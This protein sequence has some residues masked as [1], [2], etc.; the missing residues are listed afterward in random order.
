[1]SNSRTC[2]TKIYVLAGTALVFVGSILGSYRS[3]QTYAL[4]KGVSSEFG[5]AE[6][7]TVKSQQDLFSEVDIREVE[8]YWNRRP[9]NSGWKFPGVQFGTKA[10]FEKVTERR[11]LV[12]PHIPDFAGFSSSRNK[13]VL[14][15]GSGICTDTLMFA[16]AGANVT[17]VDLS[18]SSVQLCNRRFSFYPKYNVRVIHGNA[19][20]IDRILPTE[21]F[22]IIYSFG[23]I[24]HSPHPDVILGKLRNMLAHKGELRIMMYNKF[25]Y[26]LF[27]VQRDAGIWDFTHLDSIL[28]KYSEAQTGSPVTYTYTEQSLSDL[29]VEAGYQVTSIHKNHIFRYDIPHYTKGILKV[30]QEFVGMDEELFTSMKAELGW[31]LLATAELDS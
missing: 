10:W 9:C 26:K 22:D 28:A 4:N 11:Y 21:K 20:N 25:S 8:D 7:G 12:E 24:H 31:H 29:L 13:K 6:H 17:T 3:H 14:E 2:H 27:Q 16:K 23:V 18:S 1:M 15:I 19:E 30:A 5:T